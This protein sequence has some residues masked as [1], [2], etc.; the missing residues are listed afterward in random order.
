MYFIV[1]AIYFGLKAIYLKENWLLYSIVGGFTSLVLNVIIGFNIGFLIGYLIG[2]FAM[3]ITV[4]EIEIF[5]IFIG[6]IVSIYILDKWSGLYWNVEKHVGSKKKEI[7]SES[8]LPN[9]GMAELRRLQTLHDL[10]DEEIIDPKTLTEELRIWKIN[11][12]W[13]IR[14]NS[15]FELEVD[16]SGVFVLN[17]NENQID[18]SIYYEKG[19]AKEALLE[20]NKFSIHEEYKEFIIEEYGIKKKD[21]IL[22]AYYGLEE[23]EESQEVLHVLNTYTFV[24]YEF[25]EA[26][27]Y[28]RAED[29]LEWAVTLWKQIEY[30]KMN[31][32]YIIEEGETKG[33]FTIT[34]L[35]NH[36]ININSF[37]WKEGFDDWKNI[38]DVPELSNF[39][40]AIPPPFDFQE[41]LRSR[42]K[43]RNEESRKILREGFTNTIS[44]YGKL[45]LINGLKVILYLFVFG[46][47][48]FL[49]ALLVIILLSYI[50]DGPASPSP[51]MGIFFIICLWTSYKITKALKLYRLFNM[52]GISS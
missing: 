3:E 18:I 15:N 25:V 52:I 39:I 8:H 45:I 37:I 35:Q 32:Y 40:N 47:F 34:E 7:E 21:K 17:D 50:K 20:E 10:E 41:K 51:T 33:P 36:S 38:E 13:S 42:K 2:A 31:K 1:G 27:F 14:T 43:I 6:I 44:Y 26:K 11:E 23:E 30:N 4:A 12:N 22:Y 28:F 48:Y 9:D 5:I 16:E 19:K 29:K 46:V 49:Q 24:D